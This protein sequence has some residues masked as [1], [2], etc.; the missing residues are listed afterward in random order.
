MRRMRHES[1]ARDLAKRAMKFVQS[2]ERVREVAINMCTYE[3]RL[4][5]KEQYLIFG[6][7]ERK[8]E[9]AA[10][11]SQGE[12]EAF[13]LEFLNRYISRKHLIEYCV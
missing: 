11:S 4:D 9:V 1:V 13:F 7:G 6:S 12:F 10:C 3:M 5:A 2:N 8:G